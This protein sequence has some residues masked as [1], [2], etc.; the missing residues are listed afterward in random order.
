MGGGGDDEFRAY[1]RRGGDSGWGG[2]A[3]GLRGGGGG[4]GGRSRGALT[5]MVMESEIGT[6]AGDDAYR[7]LAGDEADYDEIDR[8]LEGPREEE[9]EPER[10]EGSA[11]RRV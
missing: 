4:V 3:G 6:V 9:G 10:G 11:R 7:L 8:G 1:A 2:G 5:E